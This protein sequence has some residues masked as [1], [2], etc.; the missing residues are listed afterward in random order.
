MLVASG[1]AYAAIITASRR[2]SNFGRA[3]RLVGY[4]RAVVTRS[5]RIPLSQPKSSHAVCS[6]RALGNCRRT[7][8][9]PSNWATSD[10]GPIIREPAL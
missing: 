6:K 7:F 4:V 3:F 9:H 10:V 2:L 5:V 8:S 1:E